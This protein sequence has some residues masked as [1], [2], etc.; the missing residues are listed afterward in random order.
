LWNRLSENKQSICSLHLVSE[1]DALFRYSLQRLNR[2]GY[3]CV[4]N[5]SFLPQS[6]L[7]TAIVA[8]RKAKYGTAQRRAFLVVFVA[9]ATGFCMLF[10]GTAALTARTRVSAS[11]V[12]ASRVATAE[13]TTTGIVLAR[14]S[15]AM[16][17]LASLASDLCHVLTVLA[18]GFSAFTS[19][20][21]MLLVAATLLT[22]AAA[23]PAAPITTVAAAL[24]TLLAALPTATI[25]LICHRVTSLG[26][27]PW[28]MTVGQTLP[29]RCF[30]RESA[31][32]NESTCPID[33]DRK[34]FCFW[35][36]LSVK[37]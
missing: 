31:F 13:V 11:R 32:T 15:A 27:F 20:F 23:A 6:S 5:F 1:A 18:D 33:T 22:T 7:R 12:S 16:G 9:L 25:I 14:V 3:C 34:P 26:C 29:H 28:F 10:R 21:D 19:C 4:G 36:I 2:R 30:A 35:E 24:T 17:S 37:N 8:Y